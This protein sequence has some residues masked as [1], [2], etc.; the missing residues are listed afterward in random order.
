MSK[1][2]T[3]L[4]PTIKTAI[5]GLIVALSPVLEARRAYG[6]ELGH[7]ELHPNHVD[8]IVAAVNMLVAR[9]EA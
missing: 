4:D 6:E 8:G 5:D 7:L 2:K 3:K 1:R 9:A